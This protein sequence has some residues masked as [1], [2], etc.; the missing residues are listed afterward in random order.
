MNSELAREFQ[1][2]FFLSMNSISMFFCLDTKEP[3][4][5]AGTY[6]PHVPAKALIELRYY[7]SEV[8][9]KDYLGF[10]VQYVV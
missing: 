3:K 2:N 6:Y 5:Q 1:L 10:H 7:C 8:L 4:G 9:L